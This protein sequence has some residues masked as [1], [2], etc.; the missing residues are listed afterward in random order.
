[1]FWKVEL[2]TM[3]KEHEEL[4]LSQNNDKTSPEEFKK[5][6]FKVWSSNMAYI[7]GFWWADGCIYS[8]K[9]FDITVSKKDKYIIKQIARQ[10]NYNGIL[11]DLIDK[12]VARI[13]FCCSELYNDIIAL[14]GSETKS[15]SSNFPNIPDEYLNDFIRGY[16]D[17]KGNIAKIKGNRI[18]TSFIC[19]E[20]FAKS[21]KAKLEQSANIAGGSYDLDNNLLKF[22]KKD[23]LKLGEYLYK[24]NPK[25]YLVRKKAKF[26]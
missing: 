4:L 20:N 25:L 5:D 16:F 17:G 8:G 24:D 19:G 9:I 6:F 23:S 15:L 11:Y 18:N 7:F 3:L 26:F 13:N 12:Q 10:L 1:M 14:G 21:L 2:M 22:G